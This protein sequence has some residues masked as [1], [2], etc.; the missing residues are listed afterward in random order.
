MIRAATSGDA[1]AIAG[2]YN[3]YVAETIITFEEQPVSAQEVEQRISQVLGGGLPYL[4]AELEGQVCGYAYAT[5]WRVRSAYR[6]STETTVYLTKAHVGKGSGSLLYSE[7]L[8]RLASLGAHVAIGGVALPN[9][10]S[11]ALHEKLG[12][13]KVAHFEEVGHKFGKWVDVG[14][15]QKRLAS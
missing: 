15:W 14:Y 9:D 7:L 3:P 1:K 8:A 6:F 11:V 13:K 4:V 5:P 10:A 2:I 12:F